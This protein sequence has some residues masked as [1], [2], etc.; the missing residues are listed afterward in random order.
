LALGDEEDE[1][2]DEDEDEEEYESEEDDEDEENETVQA[3]KLLNEEIRDLEAAVTKKGKE[4]ASSA[5]PPIRVCVISCLR[6]TPH[7]IA[8]ILRNGLRTH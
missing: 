1:G 6:D 3:R 4:I 7:I 2:G 5:N 8:L